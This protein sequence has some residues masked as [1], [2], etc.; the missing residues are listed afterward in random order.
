MGWGGAGGA[1]QKNP[2]GVQHW[3]GMPDYELAA[4]VATS[5]K[6][7]TAARQTKIPDVFCSCQSFQVVRA[8]GGR[9]FTDTRQHN[10]S[11]SASSWVQPNVIPS[12]VQF[13]LR[14]K[15]ANASTDETLH[16]VNGE[17]PVR[18]KNFGTDVST[19]IYKASMNLARWPIM[20]TM[21]AKTPIRR[22]LL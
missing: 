15:E 6:Q 4:S 5:I 11:S 21:D 13:I 20:S 19:K 16:A 9:M 10:V 2:G 18:Y 1:R 12:E 22:K 8:R 17:T 14:G 7:S 3:S